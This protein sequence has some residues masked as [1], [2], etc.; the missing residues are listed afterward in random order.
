MM[1]GRR[2]IICVSLLLIFTITA[3]LVTYMLISLANMRTLQLANSGFI[4]VHALSLHV[5]RDVAVSADD[6]QMQLEKGTYLFRK[7]NDQDEVLDFYAVQKGT[8]FPIVSGKQFQRG[9]AEQRGTQIMLGKDSPFEFEEGT[10][11]A[12]LGIDEPSL[13]DYQAFVLPPSNQRM[14][15]Q[16][17]IW[18]CDGQ[19]DVDK[20]VQKLCLLLGDACTIIETERVGLYR[21]T[22][23]GNTFSAVLYLV[24]CCCIL[25]CVPLINH[26]VNCC[27]YE[28][29]CYERMGF[30]ILQQWGC[31]IKQ[32]MLMGLLAWSCGSV[33]A[34]LALRKPLNVYASFLIVETG[35][36][37]LS[38]A[39]LHAVLFL[40]NTPQYPWSEKKK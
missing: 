26:W 33:A 11:V 37:L 9:G 5:S 18:I 20:S 28:Q 29:Q 31:F 36:A 14:I 21:M 1:R 13:L 32:V 4:S 19:G 10:V 3:F 15:L 2:V 12:Q 24:L 27:H 16:S 23:S 34:V 7:K 30:S 6:V 39:V 8:S 17:G 40:T 25:A 35:M 22:A 38:I